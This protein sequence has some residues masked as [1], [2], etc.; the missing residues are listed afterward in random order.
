M[1]RTT[2]SYQVS[3][4]NDHKMWTSLTI[5]Y[6]ALDLFML[7]YINKSNGQAYLSVELLSHI[8]TIKKQIAS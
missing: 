1:Q 3:Y 4:K 2:F 5:R 7:L 8:A 6:L